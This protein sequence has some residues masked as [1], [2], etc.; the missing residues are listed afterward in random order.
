MLSAIISFPTWAAGDFPGSEGM[1][2]LTFDDGYASVYNNALPILSSKGIKATAFITTGFMET[3]NH[4]TWE[5]LHELA[6]DYG[7]EVG[8][9]TLTHAE[10]PLLKAADVRKEINDSL[11]LLRSKGFNVTSFASP[12]GAYDNNILAEILQSYNVHRGFWDRDDSNSVPCDRSVIMVQSVENTTTANQVAAW[13]TKAL[14]E[15]KWLVLVFHD[16]VPQYS[17]N[18]YTNT[19]SDL[20]EIAK[21]I[22]TSGIK[23]VTLDYNLDSE[24]DNLIA[25]GTFSNAFSGW[26]TDRKNKVAVNKTNMGSFP[27]PKESI[28]MQGFNE[29][30]HLFSDKIEVNAE[31]YLFE[32]FVNTISLKSGEVGFYID[33]YDVDGNWI[34]G[35]WLGMV[36]PKQV[37]IFTCMYEPTSSSVKTISVQ[38]YLTAKSNGKVYLDNYK[39]YSIS[40]GE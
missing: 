3:E 6:D 33:E 37:R 10:L 14:A 29:A 1:I 7:W 13:I 4:L 40:E 16:I 31:K 12:Y 25:N 19:I 5:Q 35:Q 15:K 27:Y 23:V 21:I 24:K 28:H 11:N 9:H 39:L 2:S 30:I 38:T 32:A 8:G 36:S 22:K 18:T 34:S 26:S 20:E 17:D